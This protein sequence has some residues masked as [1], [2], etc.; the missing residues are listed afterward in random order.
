MEKTLG[1]KIRRLFLTGIAAST[2]ALAGCT[3]I[4]EPP[5]PP[6]PIP[7]F[8]PYQFVNTIQ[9]L[10]VSSSGFGFSADRTPSGTVELFLTQANQGTVERYEDTGDGAAVYTGQVMQFPQLPLGMD[11]GEARSDY[12]KDGLVDFLRLDPVSKNIVLWRNLGNGSYSPYDAYGQLQGIASLGDIDAYSPLGLAVD[13][14]NRD[15]VDELAILCFP[16]LTTQGII[17]VPAPTQANI[18]LYANG[19]MTNILTLERPQGF[20]SVGIAA[21]DYDGDGDVDLLVK[22]PDENFARIYMNLNN[23]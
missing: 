22:Y 18:S 14:W 13:D 3:I 7:D 6:S 9:N 10:P 11:V 19:S 4:I 16:Q 8:G 1:T 20:T 23:Y 12:N 15:G 21:V 17:P 2:I 5:T